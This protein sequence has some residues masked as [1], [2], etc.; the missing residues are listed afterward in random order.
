MKKNL[1]IVSVTM[2]IALC[3]ASCSSDEQYTEVNNP[4]VENANIIKELENINQEIMFTAPSETRGFKD[5]SKKDQLYITAADV[6]GAYKGGKAGFKLGSLLGGHGI[7]GAVI[8]GTLY[9]A[10]ASYMAYYKMT[11]NDT[12]TATL[13][14][15]SQ[16]SVNTACKACNTLLDDNLSIKENASLSNDSLRLQF[17]KVDKVLLDSSKLDETSLLIGKMHNIVLA[18]LDGHLDIDTT[19]ANENDSKIITS[20]LES[21]E[22]K[23]SCIMMVENIK[24]D[25]IKS[26]DIMID[27]IMSLFED[28]FKEY[29]TQTSDVA[30]IIS[31]YAE[32]IDKSDELTQEQK[33]SVKSGLATALYSFQYWDEI[34]ENSK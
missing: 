18:S 12:A 22:L 33:V 7:L 15:R 8:G 19:V 34:L 11:S 32:A 30:F 5:L 28:V 1:F 31:K 25:N 9:G 20:I 23:D 10:S 21:K 2:L 16:Q 26:S 24:H 4:S 6:C 17:T 13:K 29:A 3:F 14:S 27:K